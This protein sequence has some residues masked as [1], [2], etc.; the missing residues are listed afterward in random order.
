MDKSTQD[1][2][3]QEKRR[4][5]RQTLIIALVVSVGL[6]YLTNWFAGYFYFDG[7]NNQISLKTQDFTTLQA[8]HKTLEI[9]KNNLE[10]LEKNS[11]SLEDEYK[12]LSPLI[13]E[14]KELPNILAYLYQ[15][16]TSRSLQLSH[17]SQN[18]K[19]AREGALNQMPVTVSVVGTDDSVLRYLNDF[20]R[21]NRILNI[22][23][24]KT[25]EEQNPKR[26]CKRLDDVSTEEN[27][28]VSEQKSKIPCN[29]TAE[30]K[31]S[32]YVSDSN[33]VITALNQKI[34]N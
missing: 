29:I 7:I 6:V 13:P 31:F 1:K 16:G 18:E 10:T 19:I 12:Q 2:E 21:F 25:T 5:K 28:T 27:K 14:E 30:I 9:I 22:D 15:A 34:N 11:A 32:A 8:E 33:K 4:E 3:L 17:F 23:S 20:V 26:P 24:I